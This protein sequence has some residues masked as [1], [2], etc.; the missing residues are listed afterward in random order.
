MAKAATTLWF[1]IHKGKPIETI[2]LDYLIWVFSS[3]STLRNSL[4]P[5]L[6]DRGVDQQRLDQAVKQGKYLGKRPISKSKVAKPKVR[7]LKRCDYQLEANYL[8]RVMGM[9]VPYPATTIKKGVP[10]RAVEYFQTGGYR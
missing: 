4:R 5:V 8:A 6:L 7:L 9:S 3:F 2:P 1:G 10:A